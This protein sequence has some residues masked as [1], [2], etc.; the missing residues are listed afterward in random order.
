MNYS[1]IWIL[2][3]IIEFSRDKF[4]RIHCCEKEMISTFEQER[5][6]YIIYDTG[7][8]LVK[9]NKIVWRITRKS[10][11]VAIQLYWGYSTLPIKNPCIFLVF[12]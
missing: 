6:K 4:V 11:I 9:I 12:I 1:M 7:R 8:F 2:A 10:V 3:A 5:K